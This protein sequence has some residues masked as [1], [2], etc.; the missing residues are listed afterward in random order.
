MKQSFRILLMVLALIVGLV[1]LPPISYAS[2]SVCEEDGKQTSGATYRIC[3]PSG[4]WNGDLVVYAHG[5]VSPT[6]PEG[7]P[8][9]KL[10]LP[11]DTSIPEIVNGMGYAFATTSSRKNGLAIVEGV[12]DIRDLV[13]VFKEGHRSGLT[14]I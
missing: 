7:I 12:E 5:Y 2:V 13:A 3:L 9:D 10:F 11:D 6:E 14:F 4:L 8:E 1:R